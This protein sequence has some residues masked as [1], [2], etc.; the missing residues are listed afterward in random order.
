MDDYRSPLGVE[1]ILV[2]SPGGDNPSERHRGGEVRPFA[3]SARAQ[4]PARP[5]APAAARHHAGA[6]EPRAP[7]QVD[8][9]LFIEDAVRRFPPRG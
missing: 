9:I 8:Y 7:R 5:A 1:S 3:T 2:L 4:G 6:A